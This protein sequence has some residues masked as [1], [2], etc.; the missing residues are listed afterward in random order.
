MKKYGVLLGLFFV[1]FVGLAQI[2]GVVRDSIS[3]FAIPYVSIW[4]ENENIAATAEENGEFTINT[5]DKSKNLVFSALGY[6]RKT[7]AI[8]K[9]AIVQLNPSALQLD[10]VVIAKRHET[11]IREIGKSENQMHE[12]FDNA[13]R[14][15]IKF[16]PNLPDYKKTKFLKQVCVVTDSKMDDATFKIHLYRVD[17]DGYPGEELID[18]DFIVSVDKGVLKTKFNLKKFNLVMPKC[19]I[20][21]VFEKMM[22]AKNRFEK[23]TLDP[24]TNDR[25]TVVTYHPF[26]LYENV[27]RDFQ[28]VFSDGKWV[29][30]MNQNPDGTVAQIQ[31][32]EPAITLILTN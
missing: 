21:V 27:R 17:D 4:V 15:D 3:G 25:Q 6:E 12:A 19:G 20:F 5:S 8:S 29:R 9:A 30:T 26:M 11:R 2:K 32:Y 22:I 1:H 24:I 18:R 13:P 23:S 31:I 10:E 7:V 16:F 28:L 14:I